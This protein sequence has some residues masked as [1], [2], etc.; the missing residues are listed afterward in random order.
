[1]CVPNGGRGDLTT[2]RPAHDNV[3]GDGEDG[4]GAVLADGK[5]ADGSARGSDGKRFQR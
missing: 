3:A 5:P 4:S 1:M 2:R